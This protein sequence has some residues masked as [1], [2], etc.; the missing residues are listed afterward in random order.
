VKRRAGAGP[1][2]LR[3]EARYELSR[4][5]SAATPLRHSVRLAPERKVGVGHRGMHVLAYP[6]TFIDGDIAA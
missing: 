3:V 2:V 1:T 6:K 5:A 4:S